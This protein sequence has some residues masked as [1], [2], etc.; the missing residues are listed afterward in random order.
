MKK[1]EKH[2]TREIAKPASKL[3]GL[4]NFVQMIINEIEADNTQ[5][6]LLKAVDLLGDLY[7]KGPYSEVA[8]PAY[9]PSP[10][11]VQSMIAEAKDDGYQAGL[12]EGRAKTLKAISNAVAE[13]K[14]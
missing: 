2:Y 7:E 6:A 9:A 13:M 11:D 4:R 14:L 8:S 3:E 10:E 5:E 1:G 12:K